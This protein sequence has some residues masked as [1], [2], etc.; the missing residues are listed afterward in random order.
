MHA[1]ATKKQGAYTVMKD[2]SSGGCQTRPPSTLAKAE[3][4]NTKG[5]FKIGSRFGLI[6]IPVLFSIVTPKDPKN[7]DAPAA[8]P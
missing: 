4:M 6:C 2:Q 7:P 3:P 5:M 1:A 8:R